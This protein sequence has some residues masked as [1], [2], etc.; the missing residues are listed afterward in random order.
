[1]VEIKICFKNNYY[2]VAVWKKYPAK[3]LYFCVSQRNNLTQPAINKYKHSLLWS[4]TLKGLLRCYY[5][6]YATYFNI[7]VTYL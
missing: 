7:F 1:M 6:Y 5:C 4:R 2:H 3:P